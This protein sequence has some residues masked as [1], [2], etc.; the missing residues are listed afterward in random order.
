MNFAG[1]HETLLANVMDGDQHADRAKTLAQIAAHEAAA[2]Q[3]LDY[4]AQFGRVK[5][6]DC[7][8]HD[9]HV[10][11]QAAASVLPRVRF[12]VGPRCSGKKTVAKC[13]AERAGMRFVDFQQSL[14]RT[15][16]D[17]SEKATLEL[18]KLLKKEQKTQVIVSGFPETLEQF[19]VYV[20]NAQLPQAVLFIN[21]AEDICMKNNEELQTP[22]VDSPALMQEVNEYNKKIKPLIER[23]KQLN[24]LV[25]LDNSER[26]ALKT[27][28][29]KASESIRPEVLI[30]RAHEK[31]SDLLESVVAD[32]TQHGGYVH[33]NVSSLRK[34]QINRRTEVGRQMLECLKKGKIIPVECTISMLRQLIYS[35]SHQKKFV[36]TRFPEEVFQLQEFEATCSRVLWEFY[37]H[38]P[39]E[40]PFAAP[41]EGGIETYMNAGHRLTVTSSFSVADL[42]KYYGRSLQY[43]LVDGPKLSGKTTVAKGIAER[44][45]YKLVDAAGMSEEL[46]KKL[47]TEE[48]P[49]ESITVTF[50]QL[51][52]FVAETFDRRENRK[53]KYV[54]DLFPLETAEHIDL[55]LNALGLPTHFLR[56]ECPIDYIKG[57]YKILNGVQDLGEDQIAELDKGF[58]LYEECRAKLD[59]LKDDVGVQCHEV[60]TFVSPD[61]TFQQIDSVLGAKLILLKSEEENVDKI[62]E[63]LAIRYGY[64]YLNTM[65]LIKQNITENTAIGQ[66][67]RQTR[68]PKE[69]R[70]AYRSAAELEYSAAHYDLPAVLAML[71][72]AVEECRTTQ[73]VILVNNLLSSHKLES[74]NDQLNVRPM[75]E[76]F[77]VSKTL[78]K[79]L[80]VLSLSR[81][82]YDVTEDLTKAEALPPRPVEKV[83]EKK[84]EDEEEAA[85]VEELD[86]EGEVLRK[87]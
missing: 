67:L 15:Y 24:I 40:P 1:T 31:S 76:L 36:I 82:E 28:L 19:E 49:A 74:P 29:E 57:R 8:G 55:L 22:T 52:E 62:L 32:L 66:E 79:V 84:E 23:L 48:N 50:E 2:G 78:G 61:K 53:E 56:L 43:V 16:P 85:P 73:T 70:E 42:E 46:K 39:Q 6:V 51:V 65:E 35:G 59:R 9:A 38:P 30:V 34:E 27:L 72:T 33:L 58:S 64:L 12:V 69:L 4:Y 68:K 18:I 44:Y 3:V 37:L 63:K 47:A 86:E 54:L 14:K 21:A 41:G 26:V 10:Y 20:A 87:A 17:N 81:D 7:R 60:K 77:M 45:G 13:V 25:Q 75:D 80:T 5:T 83:E 11:Q 71:R